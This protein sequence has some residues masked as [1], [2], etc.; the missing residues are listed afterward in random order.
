MIFVVTIKEGYTRQ[1]RCL[2]NLHGPTRGKWRA[3]PTRTTI[4]EII[5]LSEDYEEKERGACLLKKKTCIAYDLNWNFVWLSRRRM[6][7]FMSRR[8]EAPKTSICFKNIPWRVLC[9]DLWKMPI[10]INEFLNFRKEQDVHEN[11]SVFEFQK[12]QFLNFR[13][14]RLPMKIDHLLKRTSHP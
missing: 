6:M 2:S 5:N 10:K 4:L 14:G 7:K 11:R 1:T 13:K 3:K 8:Q 12:G 9:F